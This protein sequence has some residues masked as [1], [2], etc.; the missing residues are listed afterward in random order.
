MGEVIELW[1]NGRN[2]A[3]IRLS[4]PMNR[5]AVSATIIVLPV[6]RTESYAD[7]VLTRALRRTARRRRKQSTPESLPA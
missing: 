4:N 5:R 6:I 3:R 2:E 1:D 7:E